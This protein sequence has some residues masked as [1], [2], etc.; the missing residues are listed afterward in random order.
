[1]KLLIPDLF[2]L[3]NSKDFSKRRRYF[4]YTSTEEISQ[5]SQE[6]VANN[7]KIFYVFL[8]DPSNQS[9]FI[10]RIRNALQE[11]NINTPP[12][13]LFEAI[14]GFTVLITPREAKFLLR[15]PAIRSVDAD[16]PFPL[17]PPIEVEAEVTPET[18]SLDP[19]KTYT[20]A[21]DRPNQSKETDF[22]ISLDNYFIGNNINPIP[23]RKTSTYLTRPSSLSIYNDEIKSTGEVLPYGVK[24]IWGGIDISEQGNIGEGSY[25]FVIDSGVSSSTD[26][27]NLNAEWSK[28]WVP[29]E[30]AFTDGDGHGTHVAGTIA[31]LVNSKGVIGVAAGAEVISLKVFD[32][33]GSG[34]SYSTIIEAINYATKTINNNGLDKSKTVINMSLGGGYSEG[35]DIAIKNAANQGIRFAVAAGNSGND[36]D[37][38]SPASAGD[39][40]NIYTVSAVDNNYQMPSWSNWDDQSGG[41]DVDVAAPGVGVYSFYKN[42]QLAYLSGTSMAAPHVAGALLIGG[43]KNGE[44]VTPNQSGY[45][46]PFAQAQYNE[47]V[48]ETPDFFTDSE[49]KGSTD[50]VTDSLG[51]AYARSSGG[52]LNAI[53]FQGSQIKDDF[54]PFAGWS[55]LGAETINNVNNIA[56]KN[57]DGTLSIWKTDS[58]WAYTGSAFVGAANTSQG[59]QWETAFDQDFNGDNIIG[60]SYT[61]SETKG[62]T[63][64]VTDS[65]GGAYAR[66]SGGTL[67][68][69]T[70]Q[71]SQIKDDFFPFAGWSILGAETINNVNNI[72]LKNIDGTLSIW[73]TDSNW[74]YTGSAFVGAANTS[75]GLQWETAFDQD[76]NGDNIIGTSYTDS[77]TKGSTDLVTDSL[78]GAYAR[79]SGGTLNAI[80]FQGSQIKDDFFPF[81][82]WS[83]LGAETINNVNNIALKNTDGTLSIWKTDS[84]WAYTGSAFVGAANT[85][86][87]LQWETAFDQDFNGDNIIGTSYTDSETKGSTDLVTDSLGGA[88]ARSSGGTLNAITFQGS[89]IKDDF[90]PFAGWSILG[91]ETINNVN[92]IALKNIDGTLS[93][94][95]TD[96]NWAYTGSAFVGAANTS[97]GLQWETAFDQDFNDD[98]IIG[99][100]T[101]SY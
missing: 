97:Q 73:K 59:L 77:E 26:D 41:D 56:L 37:G 61:D 35:M 23:E 14:N 43:I 65:L 71:G 52:T 45:S 96:S 50:L 25:V 66:S 94:W 63:D 21:L 93:I 27:L 31:A 82:G 51:G 69:I 80:T 7:K 92:N 57:T 4:G 2:A 5:I 38:Y 87:G 74:A 90:F 76:F 1:M 28:S 58:N 54:F 68:A 34:A 64:L 91:A 40:P 79:S 47:F 3:I 89:Q 101:N 72:A 33:N 15:G 98:N 85:S 75:Q 22:E 12:D 55:I 100:A 81:A 46:D 19:S 49:T 9:E 20:K 8:E 39:H 88:Y 83:I 99:I 48:S 78:G 44:M 67:N 95:K 53:T 42:G 24:A 30:N 60:T 11:A 32:S 17:T 70:F 10:S 29:G 16:Q 36:A 18:N 86:Q 13:E 6:Q 84:N 62:S